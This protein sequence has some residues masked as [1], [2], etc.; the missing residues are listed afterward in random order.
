MCSLGYIVRDVGNG[1]QYAA[2]HMEENTVCCILINLILNFDT[3]I[4]PKSRAEK[5]VYLGHI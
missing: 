5:R 2:V 4:I 1:V 3:Q